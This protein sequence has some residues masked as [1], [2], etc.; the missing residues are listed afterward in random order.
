MQSTETS[1]NGNSWIH[2]PYSLNT[3]KVLL[4]QDWKTQSAIWA[5][6]SKDRFLLF[7]P[8][9]ANLG[10]YRG[11]DYVFGNIS[12]GMVLLFIDKIVHHEKQ[13]N[14]Q[15]RVSWP[16]HLPLNMSRRQFTII[17]TNMYR[18]VQPLM[19]KY[20]ISFKSS[21]SEDNLCM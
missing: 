3:K 1:E 16:T 7:A 12:V 18:I 11:T 8:N 10:L 9:W 5:A 20:R 19:V 4:Y 6:I 17:L 21:K 14:G 2:W 13:G 15:N